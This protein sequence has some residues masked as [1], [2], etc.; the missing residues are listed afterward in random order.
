MPFDFPGP[1]EMTMDEYESTRNARPYPVEVPPGMDWPSGPP[2]GGH[3]HDDEGICEECRQTRIGFDHRWCI[4]D[5]FRAGKIRT[6]QDWKQRCTRMA[7]ALKT[8]GPPHPLPG[9][10]KA[11]VPPSPKPAFSPLRRAAVWFPRVKA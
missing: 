10:L 4:V 9:T 2:A 7:I 1:D 6:Y 3:S 8:V 5:A 11:Q